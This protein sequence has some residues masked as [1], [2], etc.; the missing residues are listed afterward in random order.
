MRSRRRLRFKATGTPCH[1]MRRR[2]LDSRRG[3]EGFTLIEL[4]IVIVILPIVVGGIAAALIAILQN[5]TTTFNKVAD[6]ADAQLISANFA[7]DVQSAALVTTSGSASSP[8]GECWPTTSPNWPST[9][10]AGSEPLLGLQWGQT[11]TRT[12][13]DGV[14]NGG[15]TLTSATADFT[16]ADLYSAVTDSQGL[17]PIDDTIATVTPGDTTSVGLQPYPA[18]GSTHRDIVTLTLKKTW[19][20]SYWYVPVTSGTK[21]TYELVRQF[22][23]T[24]GGGIVGGSSKFLSSSIVAHD[25][26]ANQGSATVTC[27]PSIPTSQC[28]PT[29]LRT[30]TTWLSTAGVT[31]ISLSADEPASGYQFNLSA[32]PRNS[33]GSS[34]GVSGLLL[35]GSGPS[36][37]EPADDS[38]TVNGDLDFNSS[39]GSAMGNFT[40]SLAVNA[41]P[42]QPAIAED[43]CTNC[44]AVMANFFGHTTCA[45]SPAS[46]ACP[47]TA[48]LNG[49]VVVPPIPAPTSPSAAG[50]VGSCSS[51]P[52]PS[53]TPGYYSTPLT[54]S[55]NVN[56]TSP[57]NYTFVD[58]VTFSSGS[59]VVFGSGQYT[60]MGGLSAG[61]G[62]SLSGTGVFFYFPGP[63]SMSVDA[64][65]DS[66]Q[67]SAA[68][69]GL[70][71]GIL[72][73]QPS[74]TAGTLAL[75]GGDQT[76][77]LGGLVDAPYANVYLGS[78]GDSLTLGSL[79]ASSLTLGTVPG[80][81]NVTLTVGS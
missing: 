24:S 60:F 38:L 12:F 2:R 58:P 53:C 49:A 55:G 32:T 56:F 4:V 40:S 9:P 57:G 3:E 27:G 50:P 78:S 26:P 30:N 51:G 81:S 23:L 69:T 70:Y 68:T 67:L 72:I 65:G 18:T 43:Q 46:P 45:N 5:E 63:S 39:S 7:R 6:S 13:T 48:S 31:N 52:N 34:Q 22:C 73:D 14:L 80:S 15:T 54:L 10:P 44:N 20:A 11:V 59:S 61:T 36:L 62:V 42:G 77:T 17:I 1:G 16:P 75:G 74:T 37:N 25:L 21:T 47:A 71:A 19:V 33:N 35:T 79:I 28:T 64:A 8:G 66:T 76:D 29:S 41:I